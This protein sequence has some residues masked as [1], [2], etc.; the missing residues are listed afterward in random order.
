MLVGPRPVR[1]N[2]LAAVIYPESAIVE[3]GCLVTGNARSNSAAGEPLR[4]GG[5]A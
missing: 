4:N 1:P 3:S 2:I 5:S